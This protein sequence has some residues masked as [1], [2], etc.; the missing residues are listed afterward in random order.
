MPRTRRGG[1]SATRGEPDRRVT[2]EELYLAL[3]GPVRITKIPKSSDSLPAGYAIVKLKSGKAARETAATYSKLELKGRR[4]IM[5]VQ[6]STLCPHAAHVRGSDTLL[7]DNL[8][9]STTEATLFRFASRAGA[10]L[11]T[12]VARDTETNRSLGYG[13]VQMASPDEAAHALQLLKDPVLDSHRCRIS[14]CFPPPEF[15]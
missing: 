6:S 8:A 9:F 7:F 1:R 11:K 15:V 13:Y 3:Q 10:V 4:I 2:E 12:R 14:S 5:W